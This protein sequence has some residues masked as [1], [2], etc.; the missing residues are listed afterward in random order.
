MLLS[1][2]KYKMHSHF[3]IFPFRCDKC[4]NTFVFEH[5][6]LRYIDGY[7]FLDRLVEPEETM[8]RYCSICSAEIIES[9][10]KENE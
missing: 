10:R 5:G 9:E 8:E 3:Y 7:D 1:S 2:D 4:G 6:L